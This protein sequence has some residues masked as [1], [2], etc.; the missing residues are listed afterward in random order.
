MELWVG[1][2]LTVLALSLIY[3]YKFSYRDALGRP[4][5]FASVMLMLRL[6]ELVL[7][8]VL[9]L[10][11]LVR[12]LYLFSGI[13]LMVSFLVPLLVRRR[14]YRAELRRMAQVQVDVN[15]MTWSQAL[16]VTKFMLDMEIN[17]GGRPS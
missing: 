10:L 15:K 14:A 8:A 5:K 13:A 12:R 7:L 4:L 1:I 16:E 2:W 9:L 11:A 6:G 3:S 17:E